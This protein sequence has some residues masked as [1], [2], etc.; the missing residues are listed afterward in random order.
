VSSRTARVAQRNLV[1]KNKTKTKT[2]E[3]SKNLAFLWLSW[4][5]AP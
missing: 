4:E 1:L 3:H 2:K 5:V